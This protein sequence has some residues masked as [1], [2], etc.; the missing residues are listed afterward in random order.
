MRP[1]HFFL[2]AVATFTAT[3]AEPLILIH[4]ILLPG[5]K[6]RFDHFACDPKAHRLTLAALGN[7]TGEIFDLVESKHLRSITGLRKPTGTLLLSQ[8]NYFYFANGDDGTFRTFDRTTFATASQLD[9]LDDADNV[10]FD[11]AAKLI[12]VGYGEGALA[13][14]DDVTSKLLDRIPL[15]GHPE[16][17]QLET[18]G[19]R[20]FVNVPDK[21]QIAVV[22]RQ[23]RKVIATWAMERWQANFPMALDESSHLLFIGCRNPSRLVIFDTERGIPIADLEIS[24]DTDD[25]FFDAKRQRIYASCGGGYIDVIQKTASDHYDRIARIATRLGARTCFFSP[26]LD[27]LYLAIPDRDG[28][29]AELRV[30]KP[31]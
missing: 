11:A 20:I 17:F 22:D 3:A 8:P 15:A 5:V 16:S 31:Q 6:G 14:T 25:L 29:D 12:Y 21:K 30:Y 1:H 4:T 7:N 13:V 2:F 24:G 18:E 9:G 27:R 26:D 19:P 28:H 23:K 10:R